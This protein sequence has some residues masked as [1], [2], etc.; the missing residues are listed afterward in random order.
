MSLARRAS[1]ARILAIVLICAPVLLP[2]AAL[3]GE[4]TDHRPPRLPNAVTEPPEWLGD[5]LP[6]DATE[7]FDAPPAHENAAPLYL[8]ALFEFCDGM[9]VCF[10]EPERK[11]RAA[12]IE[13]RRDRLLSLYHAFTEA[14]ESVKPASL[15]ALLAEYDVGFGKLLTAQE[16]PR[17]V[18]QGNIG[19]EA[20]GPHAFAVRQV[21]RVLVLRT[22]RDLRNGNI[23]SAIEGA[24]V[25]LRLSRDLQP[26]GGTLCQVISTMTNQMCFDKIVRRVLAT[27]GLKPEHCDRL[28]SILIEHTQ[29]R[30]RA[31]L[32]EAQRYERLMWQKVLYQLQHGLFDAAKL[33]KEF[34]ID[35]PPPDRVTMLLLLVTYPGN[36]TINTQVTGEII[37]GL[38][39]EGPEAADTVKKVLQKP[40]R[41]ERID[42]MIAGV[43]IFGALLKMTPADY[44][45]EMEVLNTRYNNVVDLTRVPCREW[46]RQ[47]Q[48]L[49]EAWTLDDSWKATHILRVFTPAPVRRFV[50]KITLDHLRLNATKCLVALRRWQL[51]RGG[52]PRDL[53]PV[54]KAAGMTGIPTDPYSGQPLKLAILDSRPVIYSV[55]PDGKDGGGKVEANPFSAAGPR[56]QGD[57]T[58]RLE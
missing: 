23:D 37:A 40:E 15:D 58:F 50:V 20:L 32:A 42:R 56:R 49:D 3:P 26:R 34:Q 55:G 5:N 4:K 12:A 45:R 16:R 53:G 6:F 18:F 19:F 46:T 47:A 8:D 7:F 38:A 48:A 17:C 22:H 57:V 31:P 2:Q 14:P 30:I 54:V 29:V 24:R 25:L 13:K 43:T 11:P 28:L 39:E 35:G 52:P 27:E 41:E 51:T 44:A 21:I 10:P 1:S 9:D 36:Y 33:A